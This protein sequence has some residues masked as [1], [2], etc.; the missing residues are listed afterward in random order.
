MLSPLFRPGERGLH[1]RTVDFGTIH[2]TAKSNLPNR[3]LI[4]LK[5]IIIISMLVFRLLQSFLL[6]QITLVNTVR[7]LRFRL[8]ISFFSR[9]AA[10][11][12]VQLCPR[13]GF[14]SSSLLR[15]YQT[16]TSVFL[17]GGPRALGRVIFMMSDKRGVWERLQKILFF[18]GEP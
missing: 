2:S 5:A 13:G 10:L 6:L 15:L 3:H 18:F 16:D 14:S 4:F 8:L 11:V 17:V 7:G 1:T 9:V 12:K